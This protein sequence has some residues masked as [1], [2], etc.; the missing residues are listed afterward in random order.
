MGTADYILRADSVRSHPDGA[1]IAVGLPWYR[2]LPWASVA[3]VTV[4][5]DGEP[6]PVISI[7]GVPLDRLVDREDYWFLQHRAEVVV[8]L[9][10]PLDVPETNV[11]LGLDLRITGPTKPDGSP[12]E[13]KSVLER[14]LEVA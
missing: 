8:R 9:D 7:D 6:A 1:A 12:M 13:Y 4:E 14:R 2:S 11:V 10:E 5:L 3:G